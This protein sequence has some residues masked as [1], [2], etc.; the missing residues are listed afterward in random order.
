[1]STPLSEESKQI[2][3][4]VREIYYIW[5]AL[6]ASNA[7]TEKN[8]TIIRQKYDTFISTK[9]GT[10]LFFQI[11]WFIDN[12]EEYDFDKLTKILMYRDRIQRKEIS[13]EDASAHFEYSMQKNHAF[14][15]YDRDHKEKINEEYQDRFKDKSDLE[16]QNLFFEPPV[17]NSVTI[18]VK[19]N[20]PNSEM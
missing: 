15:H 3:K 9:L 10:Q 6:N 11:K 16:K 8:I 19:I 14:K 12:K 7:S 20:N 4:T 18:E 2:L 1:M 17:K 5:V 13:S